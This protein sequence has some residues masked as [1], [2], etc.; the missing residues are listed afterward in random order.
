[1]TVKKNYS[2]YERTA[3]DENRDNDIHDE[4]SV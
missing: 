4:V 2:I 1:M 3:K